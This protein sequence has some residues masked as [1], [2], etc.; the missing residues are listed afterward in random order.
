MW[1]GEILNQ[2]KDGTKYWL[3]TT[4]IP[5]VDANSERYKHI[6]IQYDITEKRNTEDTLRKTEKLAIIGELAAGIAHEVRNPL[7]TIRGFVQHNY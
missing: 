2:A 4:I 5:F 3:C 6:S 7:T 1:R